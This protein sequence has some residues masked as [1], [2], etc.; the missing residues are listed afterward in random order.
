V[1]DYRDARHT[2]PKASAAA[3]DPD[4]DCVPRWMIENEEA[5]LKEAD[6]ADLDDPIYFL[7]TF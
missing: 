3:V 4:A 7:R 1:A 5:W 2:A 6:D